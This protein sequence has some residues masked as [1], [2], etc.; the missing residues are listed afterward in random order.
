MNRFKEFNNNSF[1]ENTLS[2]LEIGTPL[3]RP[4]LN[5]FGVTEYYIADVFSEDETRTETEY[6]IKEKNNEY[7]G[8]LLRGCK[9]DAKLLSEFFFSYDAAERSLAFT[10]FSNNPTYLIHMS[11]FKTELAK[12]V[13]NFIDLYPERCI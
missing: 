11:Q 2:N 6:L 9:T 12:Y 4:N 8:G 5:M 7:G 10:I 1:L 3:F 13:K